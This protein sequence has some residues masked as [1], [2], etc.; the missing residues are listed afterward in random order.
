VPKNWQ[1]WRLRTTAAFKGTPSHRSDGRL[2]TSV[3]STRPGLLLLD[4][5]LQRILVNNVALLRT[6]GAQIGTFLNGNGSAPILGQSLVDAA[7][8]AHE[9]FAE[10]LD[11]IA[12]PKLETAI[13]VLLR[14]ESAQGAKARLKQAIRA[15]YGLNETDL[16]SPYSQTSVKRFV[17]DLVTDRSRILHGT[18]ST[19]NHTLEAG[20][21]G[22][23]NFV[24]DLLKRY[25]LA[26]KEYITSENPTDNCTAFLAFVERRQQA[27]GF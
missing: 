11:T 22:L 8:W 6:L 20:R 15:F 21:E 14:G 17:D 2:A 3:T 5:N 12:I 4:G 1:T 9:A 27:R 7:Y 16:I 10:P 25:I 23:Q 13:E 26:L 19:L 24:I 18:W